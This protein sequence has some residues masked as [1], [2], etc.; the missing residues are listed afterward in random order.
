MNPRRADLRRAVHTRI[1][2]KV[3]GSAERPRLAIFR[4]LNHIY[5]QVI[6]DG[7]GK[8]LASASTTEKD[9]RGTTGGNLDAA[10][11]VGAA[12]AERAIAAGISN[13]VFDRGGYV[14]HGRVKA[15]TDAARQAGL[16]K[17]E[18]ATDAEEP[19]ADE[20]NNED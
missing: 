10:K 19:Q 14:Y 8:T 17:G 6:D 12:I 1:R 9:L 15:L 5:A 7:A 11:R 2:K 4:S 16:N 3:Q 18:A 20:G 13:V